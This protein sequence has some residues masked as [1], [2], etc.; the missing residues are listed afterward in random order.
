MNP[1]G[2]CVVI[3]QGF[4]SLENGLGAAMWSSLDTYRRRFE[5]VRYLCLSDERDS[6]VAR[7]AFPDV[8][9][10]LI[11]VVRH[12]HMRRFIASIPF[13]LPACVMHMTAGRV[14]AAVLELLQASL[15]DS[16]NAWCIIENVAPSVLAGEIRRRF[17]RVRLAYRSHDISELAFGPFAETGP[18]PV[19]QAWR[20]EV[21][22]LHQLEART[23][24][25]VDR[26]WTITD[27]DAVAYA[28]L[29]ARASDGVFGVRVDVARYAEVAAGSWSRLVYLGSSD[30]R[31][32]HGLRQFLRDCW[33]VVRRAHPEMEFWIG[34]AGT[35]CFEDAPSGV[36]GIGY[37]DDELAFLGQGRALINPQTAGSGVKL[38]SL[39][40]LSAGKL[41]VST[42]NGVSGISGEA[43]KHFVVADSP[44]EQATALEILWRDRPRVEGIAAAGRSLVHADYDLRKHAAHDVNF[45]QLT[46]E[47]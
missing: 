17:P 32:S 45:A 47:N 31:K 1:T 38:K 26:F 10:S 29:H 4:P 44:A 39:V 41:L 19:R 2:S 40:A 20:R 18:W 36:R 34:G 15:E 27:A 22:R 33:P 30:L 43:G 28:A 37:V 24:D 5:Q 9:F 35:E 16:P 14:R 13:G 11:P 23:L 7:A 46:D 25:I 12:S 3:A 6:Q 8:R 21:A 42:S